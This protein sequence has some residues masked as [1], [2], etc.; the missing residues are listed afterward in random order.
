QKVINEDEREARSIREKALAQ[1]NETQQ[2]MEYELK[3]KM[4][5]VEKELQ[6]TTS[7][8]DARE[9][10]LKIVE[11]KEKEV[12]TKEKEIEHLLGM[13]KEQAKEELWKK[14]EYEVEKEASQLLT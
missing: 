13:T 3:L 2:K 8:L 11:K 1:T 12:R 10:R 6:E 9:E 7:R 14:A 5:K 4:L